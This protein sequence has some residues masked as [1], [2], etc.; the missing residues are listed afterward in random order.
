MEIEY[1]DGNVVES[2]NELASLLLSYVGAIVLL[3]LVATGIYYM[4]A[5]GDPERQARAKNSF[6]YI[7]LGLLII[8]MSYAI[9]VVVNRIAAE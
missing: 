9:L 6:S 4:S 8:M 3:F 2:I 5:Q 1:F 7:I